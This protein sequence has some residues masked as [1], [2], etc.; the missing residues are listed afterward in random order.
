METESLKHEH[1]LRS[2]PNCDCLK[3]DNSSKALG[4]VGAPKMGKNK[5][6]LRTIATADAITHNNNNN[7]IQ[8]LSWF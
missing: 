1:C 3:R 5:V 2:I 8:L 7:T 4:A 6:N